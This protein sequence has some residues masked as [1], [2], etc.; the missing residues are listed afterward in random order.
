MYMYICMYIYIYM[1]IEMYIHNWDAGESGEP[2]ELTDVKN[3]RGLSEN[4]CVRQEL[5]GPRP[6]K[7]CKRSRN[8]LLCTCIPNG[9]C[10][11]MQFLDCHPDPSQRVCVCEL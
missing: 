3:A 4:I 7:L 6:E 8:G 9:S 5:P 11:F 10:N 2:L 1:Y